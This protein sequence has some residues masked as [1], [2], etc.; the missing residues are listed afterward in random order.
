MV[1][2]EDVFSPKDKSA[3][4]EGNHS[5]KKGSVTPSTPAPGQGPR[6]EACATT[7]G[8]LQI[9]QHHLSLTTN[10]PPHSVPYGD[11][12]RSLI[13]F[14]NLEKDLTF[15]KVFIKFVPDFWTSANHTVSCTDKLSIFTIYMI[16]VPSVIIMFGVSDGD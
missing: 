12:S 5:K 15:L 8:Q 10:R 13:F 9:R 16:C 2:A 1:Q 6:Q 7:L 3:I 4:G 14:L 11:I